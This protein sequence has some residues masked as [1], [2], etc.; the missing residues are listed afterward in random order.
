MHT[1]VACG[2]SM[3]I[4][5]VSQMKECI[6]C[7]E[8]IMNAS[9]IKPCYVLMEGYILHREACLAIMG[10]K[11]S[12]PA[13]VSAAITTTPGD[14]SKGAMLHVSIGMQARATILVSPTASTVYF[15]LLT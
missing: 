11:E 6:I 10:A 14:R 9:T 4:C 5:H 12:H 15:S 7:N 2:H 1:I 3:C 8:E 13:P